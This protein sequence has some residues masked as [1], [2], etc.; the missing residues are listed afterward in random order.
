[1]DPEA[2]SASRD[3]DAALATL[4]PRPVKIEPITLKDGSG[5]LNDRDLAS[6]IM[7]NEFA[8]LENY[9]TDD[10]GSYVQKRPGKDILQ[11]TTINPQ[12]FVSDANTLDLWTLDETASPWADTGTLGHSLTPWRTSTVTSVPGIFGNGLTFARAQPVNGVFQ[13]SSLGSLITTAFSGTL[14]GLAAVCLDAWVKVDPS[15]S[16][17]PIAGAVPGSVVT[18]PG[19]SGAC[20]LGTL[21]IGGFGGVP[22]SLKNGIAVFRDWDPT[23]GQNASN[24]YFKFTLHTNGVLGTVTVITGLQ[25]PTSVWLHIRAQYDSATGR[26][27]LFVNGDSHGYAYP[28]GGGTI[29]DNGNSVA[30][31]GSQGISTAFGPIFQSFQGVIDEC[32]IYQVVPTSF[33]YAQPYGLG[34]EFAKSDGTR[35]AVI[36]TDQGLWYTLGDGAYTLMQY[37]VDGV[38]TPPASTP[39]A[40]WDAFFRKDV[41]YLGNGVDNPI[42]WDGFSVVPWILPVTPPTLTLSAT[43]GTITAG[44]RQVAYSYLYGNF[45]TGLSPAATIANAG[46]FQINV[47]QIPPRH[48]NCTGVRIYMDVEGAPGTWYLVR[49]IPHTPLASMSISGIYAP[50]TPSYSTD[51]G[52][53]GPADSS[54]GTAGFPLALSTVVTAPSVNPKYTLGEHDRAFVC[55]MGN[56]TYAL[57]WSELGAPD[58]F[59]VFSLAQAAANQGNLIALASY[60]GEVHCSKDGRATLILRGANPQNWTVLETLHPSIGAID[61]WSYVHRYPFTN[62]NYVL[63][64]AARDG[65][66]EYAG[67]QI[68]CVSDKIKG[69]ILRLAQGNATRNEWDVTTTAQFQ[70]QAT[71]GGGATLNIQANRYETDGLRQI[72]GDVK[73]VEQLNYLGLWSSGAPLVVG[74]VIAVCKGIAEGEFWFS[75][76]SDNNLYHT[77]DNFQTLANTYPVGTAGLVGNRIIE[78]TRRGTDDYYFLMTDTAPVDPLNP[79]NP[80]PSN[81]YG[82]G[83]GGIY[84][85]DNVANAVNLLNAGPYFY[86]LDVPMVMEG[87]DQAKFYGRCIGRGLSSPGGQVQSPNNIFI[88][89]Q[90]YVGS[91]CSTAEVDGQAQQAIYSTASIN[92]PVTATLLAQNLAP[93]SANFLNS[94]LA[95]GFYAYESYAVG[96]SQMNNT[97]LRVEYTRREFPSWRGGGTFRPQSYW[98]ATNSRLVFLASTALDANSNRATYIYTVTSAGGV[99]LQYSANNVSAIT[100]DGV[101]LWMYIVQSAVLQGSPFGFNGYLQKTTLAAINPPTVSSAAQFNLLATRIS[102]NPSSVYLL[103]SFKSYSCVFTAA[104]PTIPASVVYNGGQNFWNY[105]AALWSA[106]IATLVPA[107]TGA[108]LAVNG[109]AGA[110]FSEITVQ[111]TTPFAWYVANSRMSATDPEALWTVTPLLVATIYQDNGYQSPTGLAACT[112]ILSN[113][114]FVP[115]SNNSGGNL[116]ADRLYWMAQAVANSDARFVQFGVPGNWTVIGTFQSEAHNLGP[117]SAFDDF[118]SDFNNNNNVNGLLFQ[119]RNAPD[120]GSLATAVYQQQV[121]NTKITGFSPVQ[122]YVQWKITFTWT[123]VAGAAVV[124]DSPTV[125]FVNIGFFLGQANLPRTVGFHWEG[126][127]FWACAE[128]GAMV[129]NVVLVYQKNNTWTKF[130]GWNM[131]CIFRFRNQMVGLEAYQL[132]RLMDGVTDA[133]AIINAYARTG[134]IMGFVDKLLSRVQANISAFANSLFSSQPGYVKITPYQGLTQVPAGAWVIQ[135]PNGA[136]DEPQRILGVPTAGFSYNWIRAL[137]LEIATSQDTSGPWVPYVG[138]PENIQ[139]I[140]LELETTGDSYDIVVK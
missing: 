83:G 135:V 74:N 114:L 25:V 30:I 26:M 58:V 44:T 17:A 103:C 117:F 102:Y 78:I 42:A 138:Q 106:P 75:T 115:A 16:G 100:S 34:F 77:L 60:Y 99:V 63:C 96:F 112:G 59:T 40:Y 31:G 41:L 95:I 70:A 32:R 39:T 109:D 130:Y 94:N 53:L 68:Q 131:K 48:A 69:T 139:E 116:W 56:E 113:L 55:G 2:Y 134:T 29:R 111:S 65:F 122:I 118:E 7:Q 52:A 127:T 37:N 87:P 9:L 19:D 82:S 28:V 8:R 98:D 18:V 13:A 64:F 126:R 89:H 124:T 33:P 71:N 24:P 15:M 62:D 57:R 49:Q 93:F 50:G 72:G 76:D 136:A 128:D 36:P 105:T 85:Y 92:G 108:A 54:L 46:G 137:A 4:E 129:N 10:P 140:D 132:V 125:D 120:A 91:F 133:G 3:L 47:S 6:G 66:Y 51:S 119:I 43:S 23:S 45:E 123:Y 110:T 20:V 22:G 88:N 107:W 90:Q 14:D 61:H 38:Q 21:G 121:P 104:T 67:Q 27:E 84:S 5:G 80:D 11:Y 79:G 101:N 1:M 12:P 97:L 81:P 86:D 35:Q 73:I